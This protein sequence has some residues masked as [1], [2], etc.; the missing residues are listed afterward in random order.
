VVFDNGEKLGK[1]VPDR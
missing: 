1:A